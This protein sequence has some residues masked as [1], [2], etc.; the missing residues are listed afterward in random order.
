MD[1]GVYVLDGACMAANAVAPIAVTTDEE[2]KTKPELFNDVEETDR[3]TMEFPNGASCE[4]LTRNNRRCAG[5]ASMSH[6][7][8]RASS[9]CNR[10]ALLAGM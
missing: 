7:Y 6:S 2:P 9:G 5:Q 1:V 10:A 3:W 8:L 4:A